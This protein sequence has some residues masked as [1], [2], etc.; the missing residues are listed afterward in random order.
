MKY[1]LFVDNFRGFRDTCV[2]I[3]DVNFL[4]GENSTGKTSLLSLVKL[5]SGPRFFMGLDFGDPA[6]GFKHFDDMVSANSKDRGYFHLGFAAEYKE[7]KKSETTTSGWL[8]TFQEHRGQP[9]LTKCTFC[10]GGELINLRFSSSV[11]FKSST[12][13][14]HTSAEMIATALRSTWVHEHSSH[15]NG[16]Q[17]LDVP[18]ELG[19]HLPVL[20]ALS[21]ISELAKKKRKTQDLVFNPPDIGFA[22][23][24]LTWFGPIRTEPKRTYDELITEF[25]SEGGHTPYLIRSMLRSRKQATKLRA[26]IERVG[27][28]S[29]LFQ[30]VVIQNFGRGANA[31]FELDIVIDGLPFNILNVGYG[32]SQAL[33]I[34]V[35]FLARRP[36]TSFAVQEPEIHLHPKAQAALG[37]VIFE[38]A[39]TEH[40]QFIVET[41]SD[42]MIDR[43]R[44]NYRKQRANKPDAQI[45]FFERRDEHNVVTPLAINDSGELA[46]D[47][48]AGY[49]RF[50]VREQ[51]DLLGM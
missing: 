26:F 50:F 30:D 44:M 3:T 40:K 19:G 47:Q 32:V 2:P 11:L 45:L 34:M 37:D 5:L 20:L 29:G 7:G 1:F 51:M 18:R 25:S 31:R 33:P 10:R 16:Y 21:I 8:F 14:A 46:A 17:K 42:F 13:P 38:M 27:K 6:I 39:T 9:R 36:H 15:A 41:H 4:V 35:E 12:C 23:P 48:P 22:P 24:S 49:R 43:F 28:A